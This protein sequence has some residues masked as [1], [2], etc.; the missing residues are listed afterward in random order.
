MRQFIMITGKIRNGILMLVLACLSNVIM[1]QHGFS[2]NP[3]Y[4]KD[5]ATR[6]TCASNLSTMSEFYR[7]NMFDYAYDAWRSCFFNCPRSSKNIYIMGARILKDRIENAPDEATK[8]QYIDTL[9]ILY[10]KRIEVF[11]QEGYVSGRIGIDILRY[12][13]E[14]IEKAHYYLSRSAEL[15]KE[16]SEE[17]VLVTW[18]Q[19]TYVLFKNNQRS[20][21]DLVTTYLQASDYLALSESTD[22]ATLKLASESIEKI[23]TESGAADCSTLEEIFAPRY[24]SDP[25]DVNLLKKIT[26]IFDKENCMQS[27]LFAQASE[28]L[29]KAEPSANAAYNLARLFEAQ[30]VY[31]KAAYYYG[32]AAE[33]ETD[34]LTKA[35]YF[36]KL[37][38]VNEQQGE[39]QQCRANALKAI[40]LN[41]AYG[42]PYLIIGL[43]YAMSSSTCG[44]NAFEKCTVFWA[45]VDMFVK[46]KSIDP[47]LTE[48]ADEYIAKYSAYFPTKEEA[49][50]NSYSDGMPYTVNCWINEKTTVRTR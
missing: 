23:F 34:N 14:E 18:L 36:Y 30:D 35:T 4:G 45:A 43:A 12:R 50:F 11:G 5:S 27:A 19:A 49:F 32:Q 20:A 39:H 3:A 42:D 37:S 6:I 26:R 16:K 25:N 41:P 46:A 17:A 15:E 33:L 29:Y 40:E 44:S 48:K 1:A 7:I 22:K 2:S 10:N 47:S 24:K 8:Q 28:T 9:M 31:E 21:N 13:P 38:V